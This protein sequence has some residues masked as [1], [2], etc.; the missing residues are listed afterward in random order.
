M[1]SPETEETLIQRGN[2]RKKT[3]ANF[4]TCKE[5]TTKQDFSRNRGNPNQVKHS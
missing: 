5:T 4:A 2:L 1:I 3:L